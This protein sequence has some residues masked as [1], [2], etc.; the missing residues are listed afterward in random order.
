MDRAV[1]LK[2]FRV[3]NLHLTF[4]ELHPDLMLVHP[5]VFINLGMRLSSEFD[6]VTLRLNLEKTS[7]RP[8]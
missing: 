1:F 5:A 2:R 7:I 4:P 3:Q 6:A 8:I